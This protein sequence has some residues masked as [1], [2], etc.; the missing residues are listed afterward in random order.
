MFERSDGITYYVSNSGTGMV[1][2]I[3]GD[4]FKIINEIEIGARPLGIVTD[5][6][7]NVYVASDRDSKVAVIQNRNEV[8]TWIMPN[9]GNIQVDSGT[10]TIYVCD[11]EEITAYSLETGEKKG[12]ITGFVAADCIKLNKDNKRL[13]V[14]DVLENVLNVYDT[15]EF[16]LI[17]QYKDVGIN[18]RHFILSD[19]ENIVYFA[20]RGIYT[21]VNTGTISVLELEKGNLTFIPLPKDSVIT[22]LEKGK[23]FLFAVNQGRHQIEV[24]DIAK[25]RKMWS[26]KTSLY[27]PQR[28]CLSANP[29]YFLVTSRDYWGKGAIDIIDITRRSIRNT[30]YFGKNSN[31]FDVACVRHKSSNLALEAVTICTSKKKDGSYAFQGR[32]LSVSGED[33]FFSNISVNIPDN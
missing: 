9:N 22:A 30:L 16:K 25:K 19:D 20:N 1:S 24:I 32:I 2:V 14:L 28:I 12:S 29:D 31:P 4:S 15:L 5:K 33:I 6:N 23:D 3:D 8:K 21:G 10:R 26:I 18:P 7:N 13:F 11:G 27:E 17:S